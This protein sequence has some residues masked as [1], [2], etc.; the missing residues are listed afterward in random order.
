MSQRSRGGAEPAKTDY[1]ED[2][3]RKLIAQIVNS[4]REFDK[5]AMPPLLAAKDRPTREM[6]LGNLIDLATG[7]D[8]TEDNGGL[9]AR[10]GPDG[11]PTGLP[12]EPLQGLNGIGGGTSVD[13][14]V[15]QPVGTEK[16]RIRARNMALINDPIKAQMYIAAAMQG[17]K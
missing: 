1:V 13:A 12:V 4:T 2:D 16:G 8:V 11:M 5:K 7:Q 6:A 3:R 17:M 15:G 10:L 9:S 14:G